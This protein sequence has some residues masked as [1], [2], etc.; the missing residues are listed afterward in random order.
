MCV[1][2]RRCVFFILP[3]LSVGWTMKKWSST[4]YYWVYKCSIVHGTLKRNEWCLHFWVHFNRSIHLHSLLPLFFCIFWISWLSASTLFLRN[5]VCV[6]ARASASTHALWMFNKCIR[7]QMLTL[8]TIAKQK[9]Q[10][11]SEEKRENG[12]ENVQFDSYY[13]KWFFLLFK[14]DSIYPQIVY[15]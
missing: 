3:Q 15:K 2:V 9:R 10:N 5:C 11:K 12:Q 7:N 4:E 13:A 6:R 8:K 14:C 1:Y